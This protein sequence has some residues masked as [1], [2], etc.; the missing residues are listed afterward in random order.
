MINECHRTK[1]KNNIISAISFMK[2]LILATRNPGKVKEISAI[3]QGIP[4]EILSLQSYPDIAEVVEDG[5]TL[6]ENAIK[7]SRAIF[8]Q[9]GILSLS[10][11]SG[12]EVFH[13]DMRPGVLSARY[14]GE[15]VSYDDNNRKLLS[16]LKG[17]RSSDRQARFRCVAALI[18][19]GIEK[20][21]TGMCHGHIIEELRGTGG[22]G[23]DPLFMPDGYDKTFAQLPADLKNSMSHRAKAFQE[24]RKFLLHL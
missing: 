9:T 23:Y 19:S 8:E 11:D 15:D 22:F 20:L 6:E 7:K 2:Q 21:T 12:L 18:G 3:L 1:S 10:D 14:A 13:L 17:V 5:K 4:F 16:E 24:M